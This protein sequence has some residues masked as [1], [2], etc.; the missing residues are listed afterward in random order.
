MFEEF[1]RVAGVTRIDTAPYSKEENGI[2]ERANKEVNR[3]LR[4]IMFDSRVKDQWAQSL[5]M[6]ESL[7]NSTAKLPTGVAPNTIIFGRWRL[8]EE[9]VIGDF[10]TKPRGPVEVRGYLDDLFKRQGAV[11]DAARRS[12]AQSDKEEMERRNEGYSLRSRKRKATVMSIEAVQQSWQPVGA[13]EALTWVITE[14][15]TGV[16]QAT[17]SSEIDK[18]IERFEPEAAIFKE[19]DFVLRIKPPSKLVRDGVLGKYSSY[20][21]GPFKVIKVFKTA[22]KGK[23][24]YT[25]L[26]LVNGKEYKADMTHLKPFYY[27]PAEVTP[28]SIAVRGT[29][30][31][32]VAD[33]LD[34]SVD[35]KTQRSLWR[36]QWDGESAE[37][38]T[39]EPHSVVKDVEKFHLYCYTHDLR[40][41]LPSYLMDNVAQERAVQPL[42]EDA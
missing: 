23:Y 42:A 5:P 10:L 36:V 27:D 11:I 20:W 34:H 24:H 35:Q 4:N 30:E 25:L 19:N 26:N 29:E 8:P 1:M 31:Q 41:F 38:A 12:Q 37:Q 22:H 33:I 15:T 7:F 14:P 16:R 18:K 6:V 21:R 28:L 9:G 32:L 39:W 13:G 17:S 40:E 3:H 2:V